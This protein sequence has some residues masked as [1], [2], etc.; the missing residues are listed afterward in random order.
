MYFNS[1]PN[2]KRAWIALNSERKNETDYLLPTT[3]KYWKT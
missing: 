1:K 2:Q 3:N